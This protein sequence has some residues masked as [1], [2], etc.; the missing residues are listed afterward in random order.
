LQPRHDRLERLE[1][2]RLWDGSDPPPALQAEVRREEARLRL[3]DE[4]RRALAAEQG[5][6]LAVAVTPWHQHIA[7]LMPLRGIGLTSAWG[8]VM[9]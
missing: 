6:R 7:H 5:Q 8:L 9:E 3:V 1:A 4:Q 2:P